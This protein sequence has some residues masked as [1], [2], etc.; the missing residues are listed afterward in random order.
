MKRLS[1]LAFATTLTTA[2]WLPAQA[3]KVTEEKPGLLRKAKSSSPESAASTKS[4]STR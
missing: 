3:V 2:S 1:V 4:G